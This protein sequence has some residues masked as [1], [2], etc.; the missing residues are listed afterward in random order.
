[1]NGAAA[2]KPGAN[3]NTDGDRDRSMVRCA[4]VS[5]EV[6]MIEV[7]YRRLASGSPRRR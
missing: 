6:D 4:R 5:E 1:M 3:A 2:L 7:P